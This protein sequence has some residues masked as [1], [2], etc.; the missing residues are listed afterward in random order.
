MNRSTRVLGVLRV[1][2][3]VDARQ[4]PQR[5]RCLIGYAFRPLGICNI[6]VL[7]GAKG[8]ICPKAQNP[9]VLLSGCD[10]A[11]FQELPNLAPN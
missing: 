9:G 11:C 3:G 10:V 1:V 5:I 6:S 4:L 7:G 2:P 8:K